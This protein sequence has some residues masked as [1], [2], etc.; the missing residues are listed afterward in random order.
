MYWYLNARDTSIKKV[1][2]TG[3]IP[4]LK[5]ML[6]I[7][8]L[9]PFIKC[10]NVFSQIKNYKATLAIYMTENVHIIYFI[11]LKIQKDIFK[12]LH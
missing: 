5:C 7:L 2:Q 1:R 11:N 10:Q 3:L 9:C 4:E 8:H 6:F 12:D